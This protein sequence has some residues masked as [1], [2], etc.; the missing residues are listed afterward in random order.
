MKYL[1]ALIIINI[2]IL[3]PIYYYYWS[4]FA[5]SL[6]EELL[7]NVYSAKKKLD[8]VE[9][10]ITRALTIQVILITVYFILC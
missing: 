10:I 8:K 5:D 1:F 3:L 2:A 6:N 7:H 4:K 9:E